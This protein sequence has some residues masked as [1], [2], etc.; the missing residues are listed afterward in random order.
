[1]VS[2]YY[3]LCDLT[4]IVPTSNKDICMAVPGM[5]QKLNAQMNLEFS[6]S[7]H[8]LRLSEGC[9]EHRLNGTATFLRSRAQSSVT[10]MMR[11]FDYM[12]K[13]GA[14]PVVKAFET[15]EDKCATLEDLFLKTIEGHD[16]RASTL[17][18]LTEQA[19]VLHDDNT[20]T[21]LN[22]LEEEQEQDGILL[23]T[24]LDEVRSARKAGLC[25]Q[26]TDQHL[27]NI[28]TQQQH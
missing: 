10:Q 14:Y 9:S 22:A 25:I 19:K 23:K 28:V 12:K 13:S 27:L 5:V 3:E 4:R 2:G 17:S 26:Q 11:V 8:Y 21:F 6:A 1:M 18:E 7:N 20:L 16:Q 24:I 15:N